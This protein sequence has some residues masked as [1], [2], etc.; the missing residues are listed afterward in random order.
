[1]PLFREAPALAVGSMSLDRFTA[2]LALD[3]HVARPL[4][5]SGKEFGQRNSGNRDGF[6]PST[7]LAHW[8]ER[9]RPTCK[10]PAPK[11]PRCGTKSLQTEAATVRAGAEPVRGSEAWIVWLRWKPSLSIASTEGN[12]GRVSPVM[13]AGA[14]DQ[15][16]DVADVVALIQARAEPPKRRGPYRTAARRVPRGARARETLPGD[17]CSCV[18]HEI[19]LGRALGADR[20]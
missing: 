12:Q 8:C 15:L 11:L 14:C 10:P 16:L 1:M 19:S 20:V 2:A 17:Q 4:L 18:V 3:A 7:C 13:A 6:D 5:L 9:A